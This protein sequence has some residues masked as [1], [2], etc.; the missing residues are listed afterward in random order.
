MMTFVCCF[1]L[2]IAFSVPGVTEEPLPP[3]DEEISDLEVLRAIRTGYPGLE[4]FDAAMEAGETNRAIELLA[5]H[6]ATR[7]KPYIPEAE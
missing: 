5:G 7:T 6:F 4:A 1:A 2:L 3:V